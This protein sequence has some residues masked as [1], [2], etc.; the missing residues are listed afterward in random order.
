LLEHYSPLYFIATA[1]L[2]ILVGDIHLATKLLLWGCH[3]ASV[4]VMFWFLREVTR[5]NLAALVGAMAYAVSFLRLH[6]LLYQGDLQIAVLFLLYPLL[7]LLVERYLAGRSSA[8][9]T[10]VLVTCAFAVLILNHHGYA[11]FGL[12]LF[13]VY[14]IARLAVTRGPFLDRFTV[15]VLFGVSAVVSLF[16]TSFL[17]GPFLFAM[18]EHRGMQNSAFPIVIPN[19]RGP[20]MLVKLFRGSALG[21]GSSLGYVGVSIGLMAIVGFVYAVGRRL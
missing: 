3:V 7:L 8:R 15:L 5:R 1:L 14:L 11:F 4:F 9:S 12:V 21:A 16:M 6:I 20:L 2:T 18:A 19:L 17:L 10:F 13:A